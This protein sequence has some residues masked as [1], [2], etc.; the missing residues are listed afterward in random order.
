MLTHAARSRIVG[1]LS[2][3]PLAA[4]ACSAGPSGDGSQAPG[5][6]TSSPITVT[7]NTATPAT[8]TLYNQIGSVQTY[9][10][11]TL[12][13]GWGWCWTRVGFYSRFTR[14]VTWEV[15]QEACA[16]PA[17]PT[18]GWNATATQ[19][20]QFN[21]DGTIAS[22]SVSG[23][24]QG[25]L[26]VDALTAGTPITIEACGDG[27]NQAWNFVG[28]QFANS[29]G[30]NMCM[31]APAEGTQ[32]ALTLQPCL[33]VTSTELSQTF[34]PINVSVM[35]LTPAS[36]WTAL[37]G[38]ACGYDF[39]LEAVGVDATSPSQLFRIEPGNFP[40]YHAILAAQQTTGEAGNPF[41]FQDCLSPSGCDNDEMGFQLG[42]PTQYMSKGAS[43]C[44][45]APQLQNAFSG[46][47]ADQAYS[48]SYIGTTFENTYSIPGSEL[49]PPVEYN[50]ANTCLTYASQ[51]L[52]TVSQ[53]T[54]TI[55]LLVGAQCQT[56]QPTQQWPMI[57]PFFPPF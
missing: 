25:C 13:S 23:Q 38:A 57:M 44:G 43:E 52:N 36:A 29:N 27:S 6:S 42:I 50:F 34:L 39:P 22:L 48:F 46:G 53:G 12:D 20:F 56:N 11:A 14:R 45:V 35:F 51:T 17:V 24:S 33:P 28:G 54:V 7:P 37:D 31:Q 5:S 49:Q 15:F 19:D 40:G 8:S 55:H 47:A 9:G 2:L 4:V 1:V 30:T 26:S 16:Q 3:L 10:A 18:S 21:G 41:A 32:G